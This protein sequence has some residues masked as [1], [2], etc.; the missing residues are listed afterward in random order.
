[1]TIL[2]TFW[3][4]ET[5]PPLGND[6]RT[7]KA[8]AALAKK[9]RKSALLNCT[10]TNVKRAREIARRLAGHE[11]FRLVVTLTRVFVG[12]GR[13]LDDDNL[14]AT[15]KHVR[16]GIADWLGVDDSASSNI[17]WLYEQRRWGAQTTPNPR[18][19]W[20]AMFTT[21][22]VKYIPDAPPLSKMV[23]VKRTDELSATINQVHV[24]ARRR[25]GAH[26]PILFDLA[27]RLVGVTNHT[28]HDLNIEVVLDVFGAVVV[29]R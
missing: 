1:V 3:S 10:A 19:E 28:P 20:F 4:A 7:K 6:R 12:H 26:T 13:S 5:L 29:L 27:G 14:R 21:R 9:Q 15:F 17:E 11:A 23:P 24:V 8:R 16:D 22:E 2:G 18:A 25:V